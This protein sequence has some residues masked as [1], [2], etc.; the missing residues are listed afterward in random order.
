MNNLLWLGGM[1]FPSL[2]YLSV[3]LHQPMNVFDEGLTVYGA[4]SAMNGKVPYRDFWTLY[5]L[6]QFFTVAALFKLF[7]ATVLVE[8]LWDLLLRFTISVAVYIIAA[9]ITSRRAA[10]VPWLFVTLWFGSIDFYGSPST[11]AIL[12]GLLSAASLCTFFSQRRLHWLFAAGLLIGFAALYRHDLGSYVFVCEIAVLA[13]FALIHLV[14]RGLAPSIKA[15]RVAKIGLYFLVGGAIPIIPM[16]VYLAAAVPLNELWSDLIVNPIALSTRFYSLPLPAL[17]PNPVP[18]IMGASSKVS[19]AISILDRWIPFYGPLLIFVLVIFT[20]AKTNRLAPS[21]FWSALSLTLLGLA[22]SIQAIRRNDIS[23][24]LPMTILAVIL[25]TFLFSLLLKTDR[26]KLSIGLIAIFIALTINF[27]AFKPISNWVF[28]ARTYP[29]L[30]CFS[31]IERSGCIPVDQDQAQAIQ[32][33]QA[34]VSKDEP[35]FVGVSR[36][37]RIN[38]NDI[39]FYFLADRASATRYY[40]LERSLVPTLPIQEEI[41]QSLSLQ[42]VSYVVLVSRWENV[43]EPNDSAVSSGVTRL[44]DFIKSNYVQVAQF[45]TYSVWKLR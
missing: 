22:F 2:I 26:R 4:L 19:F 7:G 3:N 9:M 34:N 12:F 16:L 27:Y 15:L 25:V 6:G 42:R 44:D 10:L 37:D 13:A 36:H 18:A 21:V 30:K 5:P 32:F 14:D 35:I 29:P 20:L 17:V 24:Q 28:I 38:I 41:V 43:T 11:P 33:I 8:R 40:Q 45:S 1:F 31:K 39:L 23:H